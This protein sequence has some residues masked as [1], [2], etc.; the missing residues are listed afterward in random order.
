MSYSSPHVQY[1]MVS[2]MSCPVLYVGILAL[3]IIRTLRRDIA[4][5]N[6]DEEMVSSIMDYRPR[7]SWIGNGRARQA[8]WVTL[9]WHGNLAPSQRERC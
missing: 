7:G 6:K 1:S 4:R 9:C 2:I 5:Y 3:I 8:K